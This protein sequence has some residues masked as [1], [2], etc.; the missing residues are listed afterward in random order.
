MWPIL[1][2]SPSPSWGRALASAAKR[3]AGLAWGEFRRDIFHSRPALAS[4]CQ[5]HY[6]A[7]MAEPQLSIRSARAKALAYKLAKKEQRTISQVVERAL[8]SYAK[9]ANARQKETDSEFWERVRQDFSTDIDLDEI[10][11][12]HRNLPHKPVDL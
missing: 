7:S 6:I 8:E 9:P 12:E 5:L 4:N 1:P 10:V 3:L 11:K 2:K